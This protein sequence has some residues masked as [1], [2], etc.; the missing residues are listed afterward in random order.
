MADRQPRSAVNCTDKWDD[1]ERQR[2]DPGDV[3][4]WSRTQER[5]AAAPLFWIAPPPARDGAPHV[6]PA[7]G[8]W[9]DG[10]LY[11]TTNGSR[12][13]ARNIEANPHIA[14]STSTEDMDVIV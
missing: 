11:S 12:A 5:L 8:V 4:E 1:N 3:I 9:I 6:R 2:A 14:V 10:R 13:K 7:F